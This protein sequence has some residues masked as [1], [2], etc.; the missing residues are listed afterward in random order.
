MLTH[1]RA[2]A[3]C[4]VA[5]LGA[6]P[7]SSV[8]AAERP[9]VLFI[10]V[11]D[12][13][14]ELGCYG[15]SLVRSPNIDRLAQS[16]TVFLKAYCQQAV[17]A[18]SRASLLSGCRPDT[19][20]IYDLQTP[21]HK[22]MPDVL[23]LPH[24]FKNS[25][26]TTISLGKIYHRA[27][28]DP[29]GW[30]ERDAVANRGLRY[31]LKENQEIIRRKHQIA[32]KKG[33]RIRYWHGCANA[34]ERAD[35]ADDTYRDGA[36]C[37]AA[38]DALRQHQ[39]VPFFLAVGFHRPHLPFVAPKRYWDLYDREQF[40][41]PSRVKPVGAPTIAFDNW[42]EL[43]AYRDILNAEL[44]NE[45]K[46]RELIHGY[47]ACVSYVDALVGRL[48]DELDRLGLRDRTVV[49][50]WGDH[51]WKLGDYGQWCKHTN[52]E[53]DTH[54]PLIF[55]APGFVGNQRSPS[56]VEF[57][58]I[59]PTLADLCG[60]GVPHHCEGVSLVPLL[61]DPKRSWKTAA[62]SQYP[63]AE[64]VMGYSMRTDRYRYTEWLN[65]D[66][67]EVMATELYNHD[68]GQLASRNLASDPDCADTAKRLSAKLKAGWKAAIPH[69]RGPIADP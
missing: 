53:F 59:Y 47:Y 28:D 7:L 68:T 20:K 15:Q 3:F 57:V 45:A 25:G 14:P 17:C 2:V 22:S 36:I 43:R 50:L 19:T 23:T 67:G 8:P 12:L 29:E 66:T 9:N 27:D 34:T 6:M 33:E 5:L 46:T 49:V 37:V 38:V 26:Y 39:Q 58:D 32:K 21:L 44:L 69:E 52:F 62:F 61:K 54:A 16:G 1:S 60:L 56:L 18:P 51:G 31:A 42:G 40:P 64:N 65:Q 63:R 48:L 24:L 30:T 10:A 35:V 41:L 55:R 4:G 11:D 13:R